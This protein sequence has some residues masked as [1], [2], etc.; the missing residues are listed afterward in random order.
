M[1]FV[2]F[3]FV[4]NYMVVPKKFQTHLYPSC[5]SVLLLPCSLHG[6]QTAYN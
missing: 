5:S 3:N 4:E 6:T 2:V 1:R